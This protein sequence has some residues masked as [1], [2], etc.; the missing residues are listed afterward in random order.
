MVT[1]GRIRTAL[2]RKYPSPPL[3]GLLVLH[4]FLFSF[5]FSSFLHFKISH[6]MAGWRIKHIWR[7][8]EGWRRVRMKRRLGILRERSAFSFSCLWPPEESLSPW[9]LNNTH[10]LCV[11]FLDWVCGWIWMAV[12]CT[13]VVVVIVPHLWGLLKEIQKIVVRWRIGDGRGEMRSALFAWCIAVF[14]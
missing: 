13:K 5:S 9:S 14:C 6:R 3:A 8:R 11:G 2:D 7:L 1:N 10:S 4:W 12:S